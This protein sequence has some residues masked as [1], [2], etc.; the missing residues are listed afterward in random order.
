MAAVSPKPHLSKLS[1]TP[2]R[3][4]T[5]CGRLCVVARQ[6]RRP[7]ALVG[8]IFSAR[9]AAALG[10]ITP[11]ELRGSAWRIIFRGIYAD[12]RI[13]VGHLAR[14]RAAARWLLPR[15]AVIA[16]RSAAALHGC[17][18]P[19]DTEPVEVL[20]PRGVRFGP[21]HGLRVHTADL[22]EEDVLVK[23]SIRMTGPARTGWD[24]VAWL[25]LGEAVGHLD[26][27]LHR[28]VVT[29][30]QLEDFARANVSRRGGRRFARAVRLADAGAASP[31]ESRVRVGL[32]LARLPRPVT[33]HVITRDGRFVARVDLA[34]PQFKIAIEYDGLWHNDTQQFHRD[35]KRLNALLGADWIVLHVTAQRL[36]QDF[37]GFVA[38]VRAALRARGWR[39]RAA[40]QATPSS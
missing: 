12:S 4:C 33:Q 18:V 30:S 27:L 39:P 31:P 26:E 21:V 17:R 1:T 40:R 7:R 38:E 35:R 29:L 11:N 10:I 23:Q 22:A 16:G 15:D 25:D 2:K 32:V 9:E 19:A 3:S 24:L 20:T 5:D 28:G 14:C 34:W 13:K 6:S 36:H 8:K 37:D